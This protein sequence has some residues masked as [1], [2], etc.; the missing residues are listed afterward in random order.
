VAPEG[1][2]SDTTY[3]AVSSLGSGDAPRH[4]AEDEDDADGADAKAKQLEDE[5]KVSPQGSG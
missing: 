1:T 3:M 4:V 2:E 5:M